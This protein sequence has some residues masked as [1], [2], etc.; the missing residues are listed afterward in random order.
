MNTNSRGLECCVATHVAV[1]LF[2]DD[3]VWKPYGFKPL[4]ALPLEWIFNSPALRA[5]LPTQKG[6]HLCG[7]WVL[8]LSISHIY[9]KA[10]HTQH[11]QKIA[12]SKGSKMRSGP[13]PAGISYPHPAAGVFAF[14]VW[15]LCCFLTS[16]NPF[17]IHTSGDGWGTYKIEASGRWTGKGSCL[18]HTTGC[19]ELAKPLPT[20]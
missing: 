12:P 18:Y 17:R 7:A 5:Q 3:F 19:C 14:S 2:D 10:K 16:P 4:P 1:F 11:K 9:A 8:Y 13:L 15:S 6:W 20:K